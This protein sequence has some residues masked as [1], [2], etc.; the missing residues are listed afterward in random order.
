MGHLGLNPGWLNERQMPYCAI[1]QNPGF[2]FEYKN[3]PGKYGDNLNSG[4]VNFNH[5]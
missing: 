1:A 3:I 2:S 4:L 5:V